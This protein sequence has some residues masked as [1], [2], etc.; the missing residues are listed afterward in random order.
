VL[1]WDTLLVFVVPPLILGIIGCLLLEKSLRNF[2]IVCVIVIQALAA[3]LLAGDWVW[4]ILFAIAAVLVGAVAAIPGFILAAMKSPRQRVIGA[5]VA[6]AMVVVVLSF[7][8][9]KF[10]GGHIGWNT[11]KDGPTLL[12]L[13]IE[14][15]HEKLAQRFIDSRS[16]NIKGKDGTTALMLAFEKEYE[17]LAEKLLKADTKVDAQ[18]NDGTTVLMFAIKKG[19]EGVAKELIAKVDVN[20][21]QS[22]GTT[23]LVLAIEKGYTGLAEALI[24]VDADPNTKDKSGTPVLMLATEKRYTGLVKAIIKAG[25]DPNPKDKNGI[26]ALVIFIEMGYEEIATELI[27]NGADVNVQHRSGLTLLAKAVVD[28][29][30]ARIKSLFEA[31]GF[32]VDAKDRNGETALKHAVRNGDVEIIKLLVAKGANPNVKDDGNDVWTMLTKAVTDGNVEIVKLLLK[33]KADVN[34]KDRNGETALVHAIRGGNSEIAGLLVDA[35]AVEDHVSRDLRNRVEQRATPPA[36]TVTTTTTTTRP[37]PTTM[38]TTTTRPIPTTTAT[39][40]P[41][42]TRNVSGLEGAWKHYVNGTLLGN[43]AVKFNQV[44]GVYEMSS[45]RNYKGK[46][47]RITNIRY[48]GQTWSFESTLDNKIIIFSLKKTNDNVFEGVVDGNQRNRWERVDAGK[49]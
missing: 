49:R 26:S 43:V 40:R 8:A 20:A 14:N 19:Y 17:G 48:D 16:V 42:S 13:A 24:K 29:D 32:D 7:G 23:A 22:D 21:T 3:C 2:F 33:A 11:E 39:T 5:V 25:A 6:L 47:G 27:K 10:Q 44:T 9:V 18:S 35:G 34:A 45:D 46:W 37:V 31:K 4:G 30:V 41:S 15:E 36:R 38:T 1:T 28:G 12:M